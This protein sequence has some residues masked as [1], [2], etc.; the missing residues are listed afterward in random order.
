MGLLGLADDVDDDGLLL[1]FHQQPYM[2]SMYG[3]E[4]PLACLSCDSMVK[5]S[6]HRAV[7]V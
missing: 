4:L 7:Y 6:G 1:F 2:V 3:M 5:A